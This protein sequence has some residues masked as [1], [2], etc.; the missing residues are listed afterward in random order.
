MKTFFESNATR[1]LCVAL[2]VQLLVNLVPM[3]KAHEIDWWALADGQA[4]L[5]LTLLGNALRPDLDVPGFNLFN[6]KDT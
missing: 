3:L 1:A 4:A 6:K 2:G 5:L